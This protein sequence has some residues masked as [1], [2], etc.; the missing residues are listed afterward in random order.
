M[1]ENRKPPK[2]VATLSEGE[3]HVWEI[4]LDIPL[5]N[6]DNPLY[7]ILSEDEKERAARLRFSEYRSRFITA[8]GYLR[9]ILGR[10]LKTR[11]EEIVFAYNEHGKPGLPAGSNPKGISF[12]ISHSRSLALCAVGVKGDVG[13]DVEYVRGVMRAEKILERF[14]SPDEREYYHSSPDIVKNRAFMGLWT[15]KEAYS[16]AVGTGFSSGLKDVDFSSV[17]KSPDVSSRLEILNEKWTILRLDP[18]NDYMGALAHRG[19]VSEIIHFIA[20]NMQ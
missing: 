3:I 18:G 14:F 7:E 4:A 8:R 15:I 9:R 13:V 1:R 12:N 2:S 16:K 6:P 10:Y 19:D 5:G 17:I 20:D 11:P